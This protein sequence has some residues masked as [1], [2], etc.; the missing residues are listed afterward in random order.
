MTKRSTF[1]LSAETLAAI[2]SIASRAGCNRTEAI[3]R[4]VADCRPT[5]PLPAAPSAP[6]VAVERPA[7]VRPVPPAAPKPVAWS[8]PVKS[9]R[10]GS[11]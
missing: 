8:G 10:R 4:L 1:R 3:R 5:V 9:L 7:V 11:N 2:D 6:V